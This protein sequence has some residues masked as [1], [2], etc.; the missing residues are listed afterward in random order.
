MSERFVRLVR[1]LLAK[2]NYSLSAA[3]FQYVLQSDKMK[4]DFCESNSVFFIAILN[5]AS[6]IASAEYRTAMVSK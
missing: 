4:F 6:S 1:L 2:A 5:S 3:M